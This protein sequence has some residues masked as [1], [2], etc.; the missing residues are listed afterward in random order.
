MAPAVR[1]CISHTL[2]IYR[3]SQLAVRHRPQN[4]WKQRLPAGRTEI[5]FGCA[6]FAESVR[7]SVVDVDRTEIKY[8]I[9]PFS[10]EFYSWDE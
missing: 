3:S 9:L 4:K 2:P 6:E 8:I 1:V 5:V 7:W 10:P